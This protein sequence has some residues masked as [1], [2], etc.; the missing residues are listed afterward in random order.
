MGQGDSA[1]VG[2][3]T[4][5]LYFGTVITGTR[6]KI[7]I[8]HLDV[9]GVDLRIGKYVPLENFAEIDPALIKHDRRHYGQIAG[10]ADRGI[11][12]GIFAAARVRAG[13]AAG[14]AAAGIIAATAT[15][16]RG[17]GTRRTAG[18]VHRQRTGHE[19]AAIGFVKEGSAFR[20]LDYL[21]LFPDCTIVYVGGGG[22]VPNRRHKN[23]GRFI[24]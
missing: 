14:V 3:A 24:G 12:T 20:H 5:N 1:A 7:D 13:I 9:D 11:D 8:D 22:V 23:S 17:R 18:A 16:I 21:Q 2:A 10:L 6:V 15:G 19:A 4:H